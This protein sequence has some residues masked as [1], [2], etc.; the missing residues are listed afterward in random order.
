MEDYKVVGKIAEGRFGTVFVAAK[1]S[2]GE[3]VALKKIRAR[4][5]MPG[6]TKDHW[7]KSAEREIEVLSSVRH[8]HV[9]ALLDHFVSP[10]GGT[11]LLVYEYLAWDLAGLLEPRPCCGCC[12]S[13]WRTCT[14]GA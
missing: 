5:P 14:S 8:E 2:T 13:A 3:Q 6:F 11:T 10:G 9:V 12:C 4:R 7:S 1:V